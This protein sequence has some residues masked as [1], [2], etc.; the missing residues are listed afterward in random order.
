LKAER[1]R[2]I[3]T[4]GIQVEEVMR[5]ALVR[6][7]PWYELADLRAS[8]DELMRRFL[9][10]TTPWTNV[11]EGDRGTF[12]PLDVFA[13]GKDLVV[14]AEL[15]GIDPERDVEITVQDGMLHIRGERRMEERQ[16]GDRY[17]R[18]ERRYGSFS[19]TIPLPEGVKEEDIQATYRDGVL[20]VVVPRAGELAS[21]R[22]VPVK[23]AGGARRAL[24]PGRRSKAA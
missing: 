20:E 4:R 8:M 21:G 24:K 13:R 5:M 15:P 2:A 18:L 7:D 12:I 3:R 23:V 22:R 9:G 19:R 1:A 17:F 11:F 10:W 16:E 6:W 14:R